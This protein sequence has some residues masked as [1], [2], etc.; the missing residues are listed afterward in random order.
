MNTKEKNGNE[1]L[2]KLADAEIPVELKQELLKKLTE[3]QNTDS[4][5]EYLIKM[6]NELGYIVARHNRYDKA[7]IYNWKNPEILNFADA[8]M[9]IYKPYLERLRNSVN[10]ELYTLEMRPDKQQGEFIENGKCWNT[11]LGW[12]IKPDKREWKHIHDFLYRIICNNDDTNYQYLLKWCSK[13]IS[14]PETKSGI[15]IAL[16][17]NA[18]TGK[19][20][21]FH[22][23]QSIIGE[24]YCKTTSTIQ[25]IRKEFNG[26]LHNRILVFFDE[27]GLEKEDSEKIKDWISE[28]RI[29]IENKGKDSYYEKNFSNFMLATNNTKFLPVESIDERR[30]FVLETSNEE[31]GNESKKNYWYPLYRIHIPNEI[32]GFVNYLYE[33]NVDS[34][35]EPPLTEAKKEQ[36][37]LHE[38]AVIKWWKEYI[39][40]DR[41]SNS[42]VKKGQGYLLKASIALEHYKLDKGII[43]IKSSDFNGE[44]KRH[45]L[46]RVITLHNS[47]HFVMND[48]LNDSGESGESGEV[49]FIGRNND[50][51]NIDTQETITQKFLQCKTT[52]PTYPDSPIGDNKGKNMNTEDQIKKMI[53]NADN[54]KEI[55]ELHE[56]EQRYIK[57]DGNIDFNLMFDDFD[58]GGIE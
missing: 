31:I 13:I 11:F 45:G 9:K 39:T 57:P 8:K 51:I 28:P 44:I 35:D 26:Y 29:S 54:E 1:L 19:G 41:C 6:K 16:T 48:K 38:S 15:A 43:S 4:Y 37:E 27:I 17:G 32:E 52:Y 33:L 36:I 7:F 55:R 34:L 58:N 18:G 22:I 49:V 2:I 40:T 42:I 56:K 21:L 24:M 20:T 23:L 3:N 14:H 12:E 5:E 53:E 50:N 47:Q 30:W 46:V 25:D 10:D